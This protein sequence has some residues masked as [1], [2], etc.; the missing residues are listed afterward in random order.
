MAL[1]WAI[2]LKL[3]VSLPDSLEWVIRPLVYM[4]TIGMFVNVILMVFNLLPLPP[5]DGGRIATS[6]LPHPWGMYL[7]RVEPFGFFI[8]LGLLAT[9]LLWPIISPVIQVITVLIRALAGL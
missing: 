3:A 8:I 2:M 1:F 5:L 9:G 6:L 7:E 4:G